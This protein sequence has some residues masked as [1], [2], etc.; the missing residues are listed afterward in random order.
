MI[1]I[2]PIG[3][4]DAKADGIRLPTLAMHLGKLRQRP[5]QPD[6]SN[7]DTSYA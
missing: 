7:D 1:S 3:T 5:F 2:P 6:Y 4:C